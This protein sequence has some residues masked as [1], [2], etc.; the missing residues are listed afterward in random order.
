MG[1]WLQH[2]VYC[3]RSL[4]TMLPHAKTPSKNL[5]N[6]AAGPCG[7]D[8]LK[9]ELEGVSGACGPLLIGAYSRCKQSTSYTQLRMN[10]AGVKN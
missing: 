1:Q 9:M 6:I 4:L 10:R 5:A 3:C 2:C 8:D 7:A